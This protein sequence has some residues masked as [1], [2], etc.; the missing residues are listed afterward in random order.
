MINGVGELILAGKTSG[1]FVSNNGTGIFFPSETEATTIIIHPSITFTLKSMKPEEIKEILETPFYPESLKTSHAYT[2]LHDDHDGTYK[3]W[4]SV[5]IAP[6]GDCW[7]ETLSNENAPLRFRTYFGGG[8]SLRT[9]NALLLLA[10]AIRLD[11]KENPIS[12]PSD[13]ETHG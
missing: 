2:R 8:M 7:V 4:L 1:S 12:I 11:N 9:R 5:I 6:D 13:G 10:E 3:G